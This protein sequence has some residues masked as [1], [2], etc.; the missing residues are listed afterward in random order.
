MAKA[1]QDWLK[2]LALAVLLFGAGIPHRAILF[3]SS[4]TYRIETFSS[5]QRGSGDNRGPAQGV[6]PAA[7]CSLGQPK[8]H[9]DSQSAGRSGSTAVTNQPVCF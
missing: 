1:E 5:L 9:S 3:T 4:G 8:S 2:A 6:Q 7:P